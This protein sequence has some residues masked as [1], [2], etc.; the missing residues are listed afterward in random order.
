LRSSDELLRITPE[1]LR[2]LIVAPKVV[3]KPSLISFNSEIV[4]ERRS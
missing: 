1:V 3:K 4:V 2:H